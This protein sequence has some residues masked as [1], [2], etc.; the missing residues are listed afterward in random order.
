[1]NAIA[2]VGLALALLGAGL[3]WLEVGAE[4]EREGEREVE[5]GVE[6]LG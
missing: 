1:M 6:G 2:G 4:V 3:A 5:L